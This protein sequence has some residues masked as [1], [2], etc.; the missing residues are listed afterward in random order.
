MSYSGEVYSGMATK[1]FNYLG[2]NSF[3]VHFLHRKRKNSEEENSKMNDGS[4]LLLDLNCNF[5]LKRNK[6]RNS[7]LKKIRKLNWIKQP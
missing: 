3:K 6:I 2:S 4:C 7:K 1:T 5:K